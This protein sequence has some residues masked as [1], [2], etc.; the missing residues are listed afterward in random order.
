MPTICLYTVLFTLED[1]TV[2]KNSYVQMLEL[3][4][5]HILHHK[6][7]IQ[8]DKLVIVIDVRT[9]AE[10]GDILA[11]IC[12]YFPFTVGFLKVEPPKTLLEGCSYKY[13]TI[14]YTQDVLLY[15][16][17]DILIQRPLHSFFESLAPDATLLHPEY[18]FQL[19]DYS[20]DF[21]EEEMQDPEIKGIQ[22]GMSAGKFAFTN[23]IIYLEFIQEMQTLLETKNPKWE[24]YFTLEQPL[25]NRIVVE[26][27]IKKHPDY[28]IET[29][30]PPS[31]STNFAN[32]S[33][34]QTLFVDSCGE[35]GEGQI[36][37]QK[38]IRTFVTLGLNAFASQRKN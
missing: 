3:W 17:I 19:P 20:G 32:F 28:A 11:N 10:V 33:E 13:K 38:Q 22:Y 2:E 8:G 27:F 30:Q 4:L 5:F 34:D 12:Q 7:L 18:W 35:P 14:P 37:I 9:F 1:K 15:T 29:L 16:D 6:I 31:I 24:T 21:T 26:F 36:H 23:R 25:F